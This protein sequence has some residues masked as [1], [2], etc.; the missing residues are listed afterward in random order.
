MD[1]RAAVLLSRSAASAFALL[2]A[3]KA[4]AR[5]RPKYLNVV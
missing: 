2:R 1:G 5:C 3:V 4:V